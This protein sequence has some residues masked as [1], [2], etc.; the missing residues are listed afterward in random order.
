MITIAGLS[1]IYN[2]NG[3]RVQALTDI[4]LTID[5]GDFVSIVGPSGSGKSTFL[6]TVGGLITPTTG[7]VV[8]DGSSLYKC[9]VAQRAQI[10]R[11]TIGFMFQTFNLIPYLTALENVQ[12]PLCIAGKPKD[13]Q[14]HIATELLSSFGLSDRFH[15]KPGALSVGERQRVALARALANNPKILLAD[16][17]TGNLDPKMSREVIHSFYDL[18]GD[19]ITIVVVTHDPVAAMHASTQ[20]EIREGCFKRIR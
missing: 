12:V 1:K 7:E 6:L 17:P 16:E 8:I 5:E 11:N 4:D 14:I 18:N 3:N 20:L 19:G 10:R 9:G 2:D 15:H 13:E